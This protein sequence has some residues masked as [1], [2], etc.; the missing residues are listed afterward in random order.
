MVRKGHSVDGRPIEIRRVR[1]GVAVRRQGL[2]AEL[3]AQYPDYVRVRIGDGFGDVMSG[4]L[5]CILL[6]HGL[7]SGG[8][9]EGSRLE[10]SS[11]I[12]DGLIGH[13]VRV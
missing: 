3:I 7:K 9:S 8:R 1:I 5:P 2:G 12:H 6:R 4:R 10:K 11:A 13:I